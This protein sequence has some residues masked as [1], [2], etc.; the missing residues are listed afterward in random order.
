MR[1]SSARYQDPACG[2]WELLLKP[3][4]ALE[5][6][7]ASGIDAEGVSSDYI[8]LKPG[9]GLLL[10]LRIQYRN[11]SGELSELQGYIRSHAPDRAAS[12]LAKWG[13]R[14]VSTALGDGVR[15][16]SGGR[17]LLFLFPNDARVRGMRFL[18]DRDKLKRMLS[19]LPAFAHWR[20]RARKTELHV[21]RYKPERRLI[22]RADL[23]LKDDRTGVR[24][25]TSAFLRL[26]TD[27]RGAG[28]ARRLASLREQGLSHALPEPL[29]CLLSGRLYAET[30]LA[31][32]GM[33]SIAAGEGDA[34]ALAKLV[35]EL[36][37]AK[38]DDLEA[39]SNQEVMAHARLSG[40]GLFTLLPE[41][42]ESIE[43]SIQR[44]ETCLPLDSAI[45][46]LHG[47]L[48]MH[49]VLWS[50][51]GPQLV[52]FERSTAG[53][54][55]YDLGHA[56]AHLRI[57]AVRDPEAATTWSSF[58]DELE[59]SY[60]ARRPDL[61][62][63]DLP[64]F[65]AN[66][67]MQR[68]LLPARRLN[69]ESCAE[70]RSILDMIEEVVR[71]RSRARTG[72]GF[73]VLTQAEGERAW[74]RFYPSQRG[75]WPGRMLEADGQLVHGEFL[76]DQERF[77]P[78][79]PEADQKLPGLREAMQRGELISYRP[80]RRATVR[81]AESIPPCYIKLVRPVKL[82][83]LL[84][85]HELARELSTRHPEGFPL[86]P[87]LL[88][89]TP[90]N[91]SLV[92]EAEPG[93]SLHSL[94]MLPKKLSTRRLQQLAQGLVG[95]HRIPPAELGDLPQLGERSL[96]SWMSFVAGQAAELLPDCRRTLELIDKL[97]RQQSPGGLVHGDL[98]DRNLLLHSGRLAILDLDR[99]GPGYP[100]A[101]VGN[102]TAHIVLRSLQ[103]G[104]RIAASDDLISAFLR[105]Y[106]RA[107]GFMEQDL[108]AA[109]VARTLFRLACLYSTL[110]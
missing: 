24:H 46:F 56:L 16:L 108:H 21:Q 41:L 97:P 103:A 70:S 58:A 48:H 52:D 3:E 81:S 110:R 9:A 84:S 62:S 10:G 51:D 53:H 42:R 88:A 29:G 40:E 94:L 2:D 7:R 39:L 71:A 93:T 23:G 86:V 5:L 25:S 75:S 26:F 72:R 80:G 57:R 54:P 12:I 13:K 50:A 67:L 73:F 22:L 109:A 104:E 11:D 63:R 105:A 17:S 8:R 101:E 85:R 91:G 102:L 74:D 44:M 28:I 106:E 90:A 61:D 30:A 100:I 20:V 82:A 49:Q 98:H 32:Q 77:V 99:L 19:E 38:C 60:L 64:F 34:G 96:A 36:H 37:A 95:L 68:A 43:R 87:N 14:A 1:L 78:S 65:L 107:G 27:G 45:A 47:D 18:A 59:A 79:S 66:G 55:F 76:P 89:V 69:P 4:G 15:L 92:L 33:E 31:G 35:A 83:D 6:L